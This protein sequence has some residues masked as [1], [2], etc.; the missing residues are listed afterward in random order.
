[1]IRKVTASDFNFVYDLYM[2]PQTN[3]FL[4]YEQMNAETFEPIFNDLLSKEI[5][6]IY[7]NENVAT[8]MF[9]LVRHL[10]RND[11][12]GYLGSVVIHPQFAGKGQG[13]KMLQEII[14]LGSQ[15]GLLRIELS[16]A[17]SNEKA[18]RLYEKAG[19][20]TEGTLKKY[21]YLKNENLF[22]DELM[23]AYL[24]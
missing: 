20:Q 16:T 7:Y 6:F 24:Y 5:L 12:I 8:G 1:M 2:H 17:T 10:Y 15:I 11:H 21:T 14:F 13:Y 19:F 3:R 23:M 9:K 22:L 18:I 4:L